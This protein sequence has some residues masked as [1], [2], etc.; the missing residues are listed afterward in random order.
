MGVYVEARRMESQS[1]H[2]SL[3]DVV[4]LMPIGGEATRAREVTGDKIPKHL[5]ELANGQPI[6]SFVLEGL[7]KA[8]FRQ[9]IFCVGKHKGQIMDHIANE[10]WINSED[11]LYDFSV[12]EAPLGVDG[13]V[14]N[15]IETLGPIGQG[16]IVPGDIF[17]PWRHLATMNERHSQRGADVTVGVTSHLTPRTTDVGRMIVEDETDRLLWCYGRTENPDQDRPGS[18]S[19][20]SAAATVISIARYVD[21]RDAYGQD[22]PQHGSAPLSFRDDIA[23]WAAR[24][25]KFDIQA[26][27]I[28]GEAL[29][30]GTPANIHYG[31]DNWSQYE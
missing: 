13:A 11:T 6:L 24:T 15:A 18:R 5:V 30:L 28:H 14:M 21:L 4:V 3:S 27:D 25:P 29:D 19:L 26:F 7:Q 20:T 31:Q 10:D 1:E 23:S 16:M 12:E 9:F 2:Q 17:L 22:N 8:G